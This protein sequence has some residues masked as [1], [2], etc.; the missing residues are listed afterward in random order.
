MSIYTSD[1][2][3]EIS[4]TDA[5]NAITPVGKSMFSA[6]KKT[7]FLIATTISHAFFYKVK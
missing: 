2:P 7:I 5:R 3:T 6:T 4:T 1:G